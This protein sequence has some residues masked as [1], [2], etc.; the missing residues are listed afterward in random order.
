[1][2]ARALVITALAAFALGCSAPVAH[3]A[4]PAP[5]GVALPAMPAAQA[6][7]SRAPVLLPAIVGEGDGTLPAITVTGP[8][9]FVQVACSGPGS[10]AVGTLMIVEPCNGAGVFSNQIEGMTGRRLT[11]A[12]HAMRSTRWRIFVSSGPPE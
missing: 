12:V 6:Q 7:G 3:P 4:P 5:A 9:L 10:V 2:I 8:R 11:L 1:M